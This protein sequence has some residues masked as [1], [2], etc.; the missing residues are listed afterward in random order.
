MRPWMLFRMVGSGT[1]DVSVD[2]FC[3]IGKPLHSWMLFRMIGKPMY[4]WMLFCMVGKP[5]CPWM[6]FSYGW[7]DINYHTASFP[8]RDE[9]VV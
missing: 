8:S 3:M 2:V 5:V 6:L 4:S 9:W 1:S 7:D